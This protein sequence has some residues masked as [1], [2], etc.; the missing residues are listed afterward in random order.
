ML[1][2]LSE[3]YNYDTMR[4]DDNVCF[5]NIPVTW[6]HNSLHIASSSGHDN[7]MIKRRLIHN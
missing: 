3:R 6:A 2:Q 5:E 1:L 4:T 7:F